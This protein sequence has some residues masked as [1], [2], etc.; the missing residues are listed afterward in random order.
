[1]SSSPSAPDPRLAALAAQLATHASLH[2]AL[3]WGLA[4]RPAWAV[5][6]VVVQ[7]EFTHDIVFAAD[8]SSAADGVLV[9]DC[10]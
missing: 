5:V 2:Q 10:T 7:D 3:R 1:M 9:L 4:Q 6:D 8:G